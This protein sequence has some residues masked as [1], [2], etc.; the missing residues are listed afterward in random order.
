MP[1]SGQPGASAAA[2]FPLDSSVLSL[3]SPSFIIGHDSPAGHHVTSSSPA[4]FTAIPHRIQVHSLQST[5]LHGDIVLPWR[6]C[7]APRRCRQSRPLPSGWVGPRP[8]GKLRVRPPGTWEHTFVIISRSACP[9][10]I[11]LPELSKPI[12]RR[13]LICVHMDDTRTKFPRG[14]V[15]S[16]LTSRSS[17]HVA[18]GRGSFSNTFQGQ[19][20][21]QPGRRLAQHR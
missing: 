7:W 3:S 15:S 8:G 5:L 18:Q 20:A 1:P 6:E 16:T 9:S 12:L 4:T 2:T 11:Q 21:S 13:S 19:A 17:A 14:G 10:Y